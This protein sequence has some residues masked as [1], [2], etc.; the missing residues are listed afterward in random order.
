MYIPLP[1]LKPFLQQVEHVFTKREQRKHCS[2]LNYC[3]NNINIWGADS[4]LTQKG[5]IAFSVVQSLKSDH[6]CPQHE[7]EQV[8]RE[9]MAKMF[10][11]HKTGNNHFKWYT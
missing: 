7:I 10:C 11:L 5:S 6:N 4:K 3:C 2:I 9:L 8:H 1:S